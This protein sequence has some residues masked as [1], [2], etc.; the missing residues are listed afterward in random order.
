MPG[1]PLHAP[2]L[3]RV[4]SYCCQV[5]QRVQPAHPA[6]VAN[7]LYSGGFDGRRTDNKVKGSCIHADRAATTTRKHAPNGA[8]QRPPCRTAGATGFPRKRPRPSAHALPCRQR[9]SVLHRWVGIGKHQWPGRIQA[10]DEGRCN[11]TAVCA[12]TK[13]IRP[14]PK[15]ACSPAKIFTPACKSTSPAAPSLQ[16]RT[17]AK[18]GISQTIH[19]DDAL[20]P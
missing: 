6:A 13:A 16:F 1:Q 14:V 20:C 8:R 3:Q 2:R 15:S 10:A 17:A 11:N 9:I 5:T 4:N 7:I 19:F 12:T 18:G